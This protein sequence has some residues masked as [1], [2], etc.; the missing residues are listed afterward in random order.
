L[1]ACQFINLKSLH[2]LSISNNNI[3]RIEA[4]TFSDLVAL[5]EL[6]LDYNHLSVLD[7]GALQGLSVLRSLSLAGN[8]FTQILT[9]ELASLSNLQKLIFTENPVSIISANAFQ[10]MA[11]LEELYLRRMSHLKMIH[12]GTFNG[13]INLV[14][15]VCEDNKL[16]HSLPPNLFQQPLPNLRFFYLSDQHVSF[17]DE[18]TLAKLPAL[19]F[20]GSHDNILTQKVSDKV[21][22]NQLG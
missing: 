2:K 5:E 19:R 20:L 14:T 16:L 7:S 21:G 9:S 8:S 10:G 12:E 11:A 3:Q 13:L 15:L 22:T 6:Q 1:S 4:G 17:F 18:E